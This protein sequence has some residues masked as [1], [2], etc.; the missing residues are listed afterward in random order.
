MKFVNQQEKDVFK[1]FLN[2]TFYTD[3]KNNN[4]NFNGF[5]T[6]LE[7]QIN[8]KC[9]LGCKYCYYSKFGNKLYPNKIAKDALAKAIDGID[10]K[11]FNS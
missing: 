2:K 3:W 5:Y 4:E 11:K 8:S 7:L 9:D 6:H 10:T 1:S